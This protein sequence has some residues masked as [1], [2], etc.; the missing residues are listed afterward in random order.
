[1]TSYVVYASRP[2]VGEPQVMLFTLVGHIV[3]EPQVMFT[4]DCNLVGQP[5]LLYLH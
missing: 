4:L 2:I 5:Q 1:M 3:G